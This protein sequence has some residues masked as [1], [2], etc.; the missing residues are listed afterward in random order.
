L[1][2]LPLLVLLLPLESRVPYVLLIDVLLPLPHAPEVLRV[3]DG[4]GLVLLVL[5]LPDPL[6]CT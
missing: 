2:L 4:G 1:L 6:V 5:V 3:R